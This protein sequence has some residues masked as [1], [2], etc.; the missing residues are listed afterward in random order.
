MWLHIKANLNLK[1]I[2]QKGNLPCFEQ[3]YKV[4][5]RMGIAHDSEEDFC[6]T[7]CL[8]SEVRY[9]P[10]I[11]ENETLGSSMHNVNLEL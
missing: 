4:I 5:T 3:P 1:Y 10:L 6:C 9:K 7:Q 11:F 2:E 8:G